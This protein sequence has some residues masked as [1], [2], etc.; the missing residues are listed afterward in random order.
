MIGRGTAEIQRRRQLILYINATL[1]RNIIFFLWEKRCISTY[2]WI[3]NNIFF[4]SN[5]LFQPS[6][7][8]NIVL[9][10]N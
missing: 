3:E 6:N 1:R 10:R 2:R 4:K 5:F 7:F 8:F 9:T